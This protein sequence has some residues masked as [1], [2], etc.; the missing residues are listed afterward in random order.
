MKDIILNHKIDYG[1]RHNCFKGIYENEVV[2]IK[3]YSENLKFSR[4][5]PTDRQTSEYKIISDLYKFGVNVAAP[6][7]F[8]KKNL[9]SIFR[10]IQG[11]SLEYA[12][13]ISCNKEI[14]LKNIV[15]E[16]IKLHEF[17]SEDR[18]SN[19]LRFSSN[20]IYRYFCEFFDSY[21]IFEKNSK[22]EHYILD[23][24]SKN[25][26][27]FVDCK[28]VIGNK[29]LHNYNIIVDLDEKVYFC[30]FEK[31]YPHPYYIDIAYF[32]NHNFKSFEV[33]K[34]LLDFYMKTNNEDCKTFYFMIDFYL[35]LDNLKTIKNIIN[36]SMGK[37][38]KWEIADGN[39]RTKKYEQDIFYGMTLNRI[40]TSDI[41]YY[42]KLLNRSIFSNEKVIKD[43]I[44]LIN[45]FFVS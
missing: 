11:H 12:L 13:G 23:Y 19:Y 5:I 1:M 7:L 4:H 45:L 10:F 36:N 35:L 32:I 18:Y 25:S 9:I 27:K 2:F 38:V 6:V 41:S 37:R 14:L 21:R 16:M 40:R 29:E 20:D 34:F 17:K 28:Y 26:E 8:D 15:K 39:I 24:I 31:S 33:K 30:D 43:L 3:K 22:Y 42:V 44:D